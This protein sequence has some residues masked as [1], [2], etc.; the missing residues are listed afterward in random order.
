MRILYF[1]RDYNTHDH[2]FLKTLAEYDHEIG[3]LSLERGDI[4]LEKRPI[5]DSVKK[6]HWAG[7][8]PNPG[9]VDFPRLLISL[10]KVLREFK[11]DLVQAGPVQRAAF[12]TALSGFHPL[13]TMSWGYDLLVDVHKGPAWEWA[14]RYTLKHS[15]SFVG[16][17]KVIRDLAENYGMEPDRIVTFPWGA[18][19]DRFSPVNNKSQTN[20]R[21]RLGWDNG[22]FV[23]LSNRGW[24]EIYGVVDLANAF[25]AAVKQKPGLRLLMLGSGPLAKKIDNIFSTAGVSEYVNFPGQVSQDELVEYY[26]SADLYIST[27][28]SDGTSISLLEALS[29]GTPVLVTDIPGNKEWISNSTEVGWLFQDGNVQELVQGILQAYDNCQKLPGMGIAARKLAVN[30]ANWLV[31]FPTLFKAYQIAMS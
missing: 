24:S 31:N 6:I 28:H 23:L 22:N 18:N 4:Q 8:L 19:I 25:V 15:D 16:D 5:P 10:R 1:T 11:P 26:Q 3:F 12:L 30:K 27:S 20:L 17:C 2:R 9:W 21:K 13:V 14:T 29:S 7:G